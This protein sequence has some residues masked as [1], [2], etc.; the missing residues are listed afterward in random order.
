MPVTDHSDSLRTRNLAVD[1]ALTLGDETTLSFQEMAAPPTPPTGS[2]VVYAKSDGKLYAKDDTGVETDLTAG[3]SAGLPVVDSTAIAKGSVDGTKQVRLEVDGLT[4]GTTRVLSV[5]DV[6]GTIV[7]TG[8]ADLVITDG[9]TG[10]G[11]AAGA[12]TN[13]GLS[14]GSDVQAHDSDLDALAALAGNGLIARTGVGTSAVRTITGTAGKIAIT[15]GDGL[16]GDPTITIP[17]SPTLVV[18]TIAD[19]S[20]ATHD[21]QNAAGGGSLDAVAIGSGTFVSAR[22]AAKHRTITKIFYIEDPLA[23]DSFPVTFVADN[24]TFVQ[25]RGVTDVGTVDFNLEHRNTDSPDVVGTDILS[26]DLQA[27]SSGASTMAFVSAG[28]VAAEQWL[29]YNASAVAGAPTK[30]WVVLEYTID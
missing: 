26:S 15:D 14:I 23:G 8:G 17:D 29:N 30:L 4:T 25:V 19:L 13:L 24:V 18:P 2:V 7:V 9:G 3:G 11:T 28:S 5:Q 27:T 21:H 22:I 6:D 12:R 10:A 16:A 20:N 1:D